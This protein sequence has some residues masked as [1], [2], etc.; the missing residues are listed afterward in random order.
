[1]T[2]SPHKPSG[3]KPSF[4][5]RGWTRDELVV[6]LNIYEKLPFGQFD[7]DQPVIQ[8]VASRLSRSPASVAMKL[9]NLASLDP[10]IKARGRRGLPGASALDRRIWAEFHEQRERVLAESESAIRELFGVAEND[11]LDVVKGTGV[12]VR[13]AVR[14]PDGPTEI[15]TQVSV[16]RGQQFFRQ[17]ILNTFDGA[18]CV[19]G[20]KVRELLVASHIAPWAIFPKERLNPRNGLCLSRLHDGAF[21]CGLIT[22]DEAFRLVIS[23]KLKDHLPHHAIESNFTKFEGMRICTPQPAPELRFLEYHRTEIFEKCKAT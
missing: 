23:R 15:S 4:Q 11:D 20:I 8:D 18:C 5:P 2:L 7:E 17:M 21:D 14:Q 22:F 3:S 13:R 1:L 16:R 19:T 10:A 6:L 9:C 12:R